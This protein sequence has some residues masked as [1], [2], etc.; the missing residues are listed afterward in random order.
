MHTI[1]EEKIPIDLK[2][3][4]QIAKCKQMI[5]LNR[6]GKYHQFNLSA[7]EELYMRYV[8]QFSEQFVWYVAVGCDMVAESVA[9]N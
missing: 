1:S 5:D 3:S 7:I 9:S 2:N 6:K 4:V 8:K